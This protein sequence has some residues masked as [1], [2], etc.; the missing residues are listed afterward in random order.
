[1]KILLLGGNGQLGFEL[2]RTLAV[3]GQVI[4]TTRTGLLPE[5]AKAL[6]MDFSDL[7]Q[8]EAIIDEQRPNVIVNAVAYTKVDDAEKHPEDADRLNHLMPAILAKKAREHGALLIHFSTDYVYSG[9]QQRPWTER[10]RPEPQSV[11]G[12][13][14]LAGDRAIIASECAH[15][16]I[17]TQW[18]YAARGQNFMRTMLARA[19]AGSPLKI[20]DDQ[21]GAPTP[22]RVVAAAVACMLARWLTDLS[23]PGQA[24]SGIYHLATRDQC[25]WY[26][27]ADAIFQEAHNIGVLQ[28]RP[29]YAA[30]SSADFQAVAK[31]PRYSVLNCDK[32][33]RDFDLRLPDWRSVLRQTLHEYQSLK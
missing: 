29:Q 6:R 9:D 28:E 4:A 31:R 1:M 13:T 19:K 33:T 12:R 27:F 7:S 23:T 25:S 20:V 18:L 5:G 26:E 32:L 21:I 22:V 14:K 2:H 3:Y 17:R 8:L 15:W 30:V 11:Y 16:I 10:D 24:L